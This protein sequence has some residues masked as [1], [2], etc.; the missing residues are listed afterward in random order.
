[1]R[2]ASRKQSGGHQIEREDPCNFHWMTL[3]VVEVINLQKLS[4]LSIR[5]SWKVSK[6][7]SHFQNEI[8]AGTLSLSSQI[9]CPAW[10]LCVLVV[11]IGSPLSP[12]SFHD[13]AAFHCE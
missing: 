13:P 5:A 6:I 4:F 2:A 1:M 11:N 7:E 10:C 3:L 12:P 9:V 8:L